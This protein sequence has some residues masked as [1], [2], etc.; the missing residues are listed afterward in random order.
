[1]HQYPYQEDPNHNNRVYSVTTRDCIVNLRDGILSQLKGIGTLQACAEIQRLIQELPDINWLEKVLI[2]AQEN[3]RQ[4]TWQPPAPEDILHLI[5]NKNKRLV[6]NGEQLINV[7][8]E[9]LYQLELELQ[10]ETPA[11]RDLWDKNNNGSDLFRPIDENAFSDYVKRFLDKD[12]K[13]RGIIINREVE[14]RR[15]SGGNPGERTDI[16][17]DAVT[18]LPTVETYD[19]IT[20]I[21]EV[22]GCW[23]KDLQTAMESQLVERYLA[24]NTCKY[25]LY[26]IGWFS[27]IQWDS[28]DSRKKATPTTSIEEAKAR[29]DAQAEALS[30]SGK[31]VRAYVMNTAL[32]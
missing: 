7:L 25:G 10:G 8:I 14:L 27:C 31:V 18:K 17:V 15:G 1:V 30:L 6:Q 24:D 28:R 4:K 5:L 13:L 3:M 22:K 19:S 12:L 26:L 32:R 11:A 9:S 16:H 20:V 29:F 23:H 2:S 21:I